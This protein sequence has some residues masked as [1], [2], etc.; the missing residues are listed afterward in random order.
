M[1]HVVK[2]QSTSTGVAFCF[3]TAIAFEIIVKLGIMTWSPFFK[4]IV[5]NA[6]SKAAVPFETD[7]QY[8]LSII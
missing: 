3:I 8:F 6:I 2:S 4:L 7:E 5:F 1:F